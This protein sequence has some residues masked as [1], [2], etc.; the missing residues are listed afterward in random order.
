MIGRYNEIIGAPYKIPCK[1]AVNSNI[2]LATLIS[3][4]DGISIYSGDRVLLFNQSDGRENGIYTLSSFGRLE[5]ASDFVYLDDAYNG[6][7]VL[8]NQG[9]Y[10]SKTFVLSTVDPITLGSTQLNFSIYSAGGSGGSGTSGSS[11]T[12]GTSGSSGSD[13]IANPAIIMMY[14]SLGI[15]NI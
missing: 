11:G 12:S 13:G 6:V 4:L 5:R 15:L 1:V 3:T 14:T 7:L 8:I 10:A 2:I 9:T